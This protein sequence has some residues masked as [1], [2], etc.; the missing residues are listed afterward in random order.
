MLTQAGQATATVAASRTLTAQSPGDVAVPRTGTRRP[1]LRGVGVGLL[2]LAT[3]VLGFA[4]YL[5]GLSGVQEAR[6]QSL[7]Y[8][9]LQIQLANQVAPLGPT[10]PGSPVAVL[11]VPGI[12]IR[13]MVVVEGTS[14]ENLSL[15]PGLLRDT[16]FPGQA[17]VSV[18]YGRRATFGA[19]FARL[20]RLRPGQLIRVITGQGASTYTVAAVSNSTRVIE[21]PAPDR[22]VLLTAASPVIPGGYLE[23]DA[24]LTSTPHPGPGV[25]SVIN[26]PELP[27]AGDGSALILTVGWGLLLALVS[28][29]GTVAASRWSPWAAYLGAAPLA[30]AVLWN[31]YQSLSALLPNAY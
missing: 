19:P 8:T 13:D 5:Y 2:L 24:R 15:G 26:A 30:L 27:L 28:A 29:G 3:V 22:L 9:R 18:I 20:A 17:G 23:V 1:V 11:S 16:P 10:A 25:V 4:G 31:L 6:S 7:M 14:P 21:D 12:G